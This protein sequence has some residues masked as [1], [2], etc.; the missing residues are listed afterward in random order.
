MPCQAGSYNRTIGLSLNVGVVVL[1]AVSPAAADLGSVTLHPA[2][3]DTGASTTCLSAHL[4]GALGLR[5]MGLRR[6][7]S[8]TE[9]KP[10]NVY[11]VDLSIPFGTTAFVKRGSAVA[12]RTRGRHSLNPV[13]GGPRFA[14][15]PST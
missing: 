4:A 1:G 3:V 2:L 15:S 9:V 12:Y 13:G 8:A 5:P 14:R 6:M 10:V 11:L 7:V